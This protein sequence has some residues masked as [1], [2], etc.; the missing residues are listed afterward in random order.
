[1]VVKKLFA[2]LIMFPENILTRKLELKDQM[3]VWSR[4]FRYLFYDTEWL[5]GIVMYKVLVSWAEPLEPNLEHKS[6]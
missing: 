1:M 4:S 6:R 3:L 5:N 2:R